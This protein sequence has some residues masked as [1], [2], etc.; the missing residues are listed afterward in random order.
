MT[1]KGAPQSSSQSSDGWRA[2]L[3]HLPLAN[4]NGPNTVSQSV[5]EQGRGRLII[6]R[7]SKS[8]N[9]ADDVDDCEGRRRTTTLTKSNAKSHQ[10]FVFVLRADQS[11]MI[12][13]RVLRVNIMYNKLRW[14]ID[15][16]GDKSIG[17]IFN[18]KWCM[19]SGWRS[20]FIQNLI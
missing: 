5:I 18:H 3:P 13:V 2:L 20:E 4:E 15:A 19:W 12:W 14:F 10:Q 11:G 17:G 6:P 7:V 8:F 1:L 9:D 16:Y